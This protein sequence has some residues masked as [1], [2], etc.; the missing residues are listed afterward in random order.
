MYP[1]RQPTAHPIGENWR[2]RCFA[3]LLRGA[4][5]DP[6]QLAQL[7]EIMLQASTR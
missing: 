7:G 6:G 1:V 3:A 2:V 4:P 5:G